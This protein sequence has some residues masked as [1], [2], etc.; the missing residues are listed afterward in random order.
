MPDLTL[1]PMADDQKLLA[2]VTDFYHKTLL[3]SDA[4]RSYLKERGLDHP[5]LIDHFMLGYSERS[6]GLKLPGKETKAGRAIRERL[7]KIGLFRDTGH[8]H[9]NGCVV[10]PINAPDGSRR[11]LDIYGRK[12]MAGRLRKGT[13]LDLHLDEKM[14]GVFNVEGLAGRGEAVLCR[15][16]FD[17]L[18]FWAS[19]YRNAT[20]VFGGITDDLLAAFT[21]FSIKRVLVTDEAVAEKLL[22]AGLEVFVVRLPINMTVNAFALQSQDPADA[23][24]SLL[25][26][27]EWMGKGQRPVAGI[28]S[29]SRTTTQTPP[30]HID[31]EEAEAEDDD[32]ADQGDDGVEAGEGGNEAGKDSTAFQA[33]LPDFNLGSSTATT[34]AKS[35]A[36]CPASPWSSPWCGRVR[37]AST[38]WSART[39]C[40]A[41]RRGC[42]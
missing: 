14:P 29:A 26:A 17:V 13:A 28:A 9:L 6:L 39:P 32:L 25:R 38:A 18:T 42:E 23:L 8:E 2:L 10:F 21:E 30:P 41:G 36:R 20:C 11:I 34:S 12:V 7:Q 15:S 40:C 35:T 5:A 3:E 22:A 16:P 4:A 37:V 31:L 24:G 1:D 33:N 27:A 19:G